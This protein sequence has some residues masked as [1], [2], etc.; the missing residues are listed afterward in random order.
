[1]KRTPLPKVSSPSLL[2]AAPLRRAALVV[3][4]PRTVNSNSAWQPA[5]KP[6]LDL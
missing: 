4:Q 5:G 6:G 2:S 3:D 1:M